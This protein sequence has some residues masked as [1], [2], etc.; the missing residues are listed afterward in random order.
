MYNVRVEVRDYDLDK[1]EK[2]IEAIRKE[3]GIHINENTDENE[4]IFEGLHYGTEGEI[5]RTI[6]R[7]NGEFCEIDI[8]T[9]RERVREFTFEDYRASGL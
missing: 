1:K 3:Y 6:W 7:E 5:A 4:L 8:I 2:I 9:I